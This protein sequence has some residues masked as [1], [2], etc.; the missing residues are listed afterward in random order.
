MVEKTQTQVKIKR[1]KHRKKRMHAADRYGT[2][3]G[4]ETAW[5][6]VQSCPDQ[7]EAQQQGGKR[8]NRPSGAQGQSKLKGQNNLL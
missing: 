6:K 3:E 5:L 1:I 2:L 7:E 8:E 4:T